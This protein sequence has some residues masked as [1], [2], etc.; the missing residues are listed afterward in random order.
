[1]NKLNFMICLIFLSFSA[2]AQILNG[3]FEQ[4]SMGE[5]SDW[6]SNNVNE[7]EI[8]LTP[9]TQSSFS[10]GGSY[11]LKG[12][13][14]EFEIKG[15]T[16]TYAPTLNSGTETSP[17]FQF[18]G[19]PKSVR[20]YYNY[21]SAGGD[22]FVANVFLLNGTDLLAVSG[23]TNYSS[24]GPGWHELN[25]YFFYLD[26]VTTP[27]SMQIIF[28]IGPTGGTE[29]HVGSV[30]YIDDFPKM[31]LIKPP[32]EPEELGTENLVYIAGETDTIK[33]DGGGALNVDIKYS[34]D[35]GATYQQIV[36]NYPAD[37]TRYFW[38]VPGSLLTRKAKIKILE[39]Q[40]T[41]NEIKSVEFNI[42]PWQLTRLD[43][44]D[45][46]ELFKPNEDGWLFS[47]ATNNVWP[48][49]WW[50]QFDY[51]GT[52][53]I[54]NEPYPRWF[55]F[56]NADPSD[57]PDWPLFVD[58]FGEVN[59]Y[60]FGNSYRSEATTHWG[61]IF[62]GIRSNWGGSCFGFAV[63]S[64]LG[65]YHN[66]SLIQRF[67]NI[68]NFTNLFT[69]PLNNDSRFV[70]NH[71][72]IH[73]FGVESRANTNARWSTYTPRQ[74][75]QDIKDMFRK[76]NGDG[77]ALL[78][79]NNNG[80]GGHAVTP[81]KLERIGTTSS[82]KVRVYDSRAPGSTNNFIR[83]DSVSNMWIDQTGLNYGIGSS[84]CFL[85]R[86]S[87]NFLS[88]PTIPT[89]PGQILAAMKSP[90]GS[91]NMTIYNTSYA[92][93][94]ITSSNGDQIGFQ[95]SIAFSNIT[96][97]VPMIPLT[98]SYQPPIG[99]DLP[100]DSYSLQ[101]NNFTDSLSYV[102]FLADSTIYNYR[103][104]DASNNEVDELNFSES[105][106]GII[107]PD[108]IDKNTILETIILEDSTSEKVFVTSNVKISA[109]DSIHI[110][111]KDR[112]EL[113]L[114]NYGESMNYDLQVRIAS[115]NGQSIFFH[116]AI[117]LTQNSSHQIV[118]VWENLA[119]D[120]V[121]IL[122][123]LGND[124]TIDDSLFITNQATNIENQNYV[125]I[126]DNYNL[127]QNYPNPF[128]PTTT[129]SFDLPQQSEVNLTVYNTLG[130]EVTTLINEVKH[131]G[132]HH[133][134]FDASNLP[135]GVYIYRIKA[136]LYT[137]T[138]KMVLVK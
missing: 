67:P 93:I 5:P 135:S 19:K 26:T 74:L 121:K 104:F 9:I 33:W 36:S 97:G 89:A 53:P 16:L 49:S 116:M 80:S 12:E 39:S 130:Q 83:I 18:T 126:P 51:S 48:Q 96:N 98:T 72:M 85:S 118:P 63:S 32:G 75:L 13:V 56:I 50:Q 17:V 40:N 64:L 110:R 30:F 4:W 69:V 90:N 127:L 61:G 6:L 59:C 11:A 100:Q 122:I 125:G 29:T 66:S 77:R 70:V 123:D 27:T 78:Y 34:V 31:S 115:A 103:R 73:Q 71:Y 113:L 124:G 62:S 60:V 129:I 68:G 111:E 134:V 43:A 28:L 52:D 76:E 105:G 112:S 14:V 55:P 10:H 107:N 35:N 24:T 95:D 22:V 120:P 45:K 37:S 138:K 88:T 94:I 91:S 84:G 57:F 101:I 131:A 119:N 132:R 1:M 99:Y 106:V 79:Y 21:E 38:T 3:G 20:G 25:F 65:F 2:Q 117:P 92:D 136:G 102:F 87:V 108:P 86:E 58:V 15:K 82:F 41:S 7:P 46:F 44:S 109:G 47:N 133:I 81:Y 42:K 114:Q 54:T 128:N 23:I 137:G 8:I